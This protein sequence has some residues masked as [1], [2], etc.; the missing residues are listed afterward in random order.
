MS[1]EEDFPSLCKFFTE[2]K[3]PIPE[4]FYILVVE[5]CCLDKQKVGEARDRLQMNLMKHC[6]TNKCFML[7]NEELGLKG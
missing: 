7:F 1:F 2:D 5:K 4:V 3:M 6:D